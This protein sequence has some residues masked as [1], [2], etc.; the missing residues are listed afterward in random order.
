MPRACTFNDENCHFPPPP[1]V[2]HTYYL[3]KKT[4][5]P[6]SFVLLDT[7]TRKKPCCSLF[8]RHAAQH[9]RNRQ[10]SICSRKTYFQFISKPYKRALGRA[11]FNGSFYFHKNPVIAPL[12]RIPLHR[13]LNVLHCTIVTCTRT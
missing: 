10:V 6:R 13:T 1:P 9:V 8:C 12:I 7:R 4:N 2:P 5:V 11:T 3:R